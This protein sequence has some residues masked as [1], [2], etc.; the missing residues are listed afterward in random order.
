M[1][2]TGPTQNKSVFRG[3][4]GLLV[5]ACSLLSINCF[6]DS[7]DPVLPSWDVEITAPLLNR[8]YTL[9]EIVRKD[10]SILRTGVGGEITYALS[11]NLQPTFLG[12]LITLSLPDTSKSVRFGAF[13]VTAA[14]V[15]VPIGIPWLPP[16]ATVPIPDT[17]IQVGDVRDTIPSFQQVTFAQ[18]TISLTVTNNLPVPIEAIAP[19]ILV[20][21]LNEVV[22]T[23]SFSPSG[24]PPNSSATASDDLS[25]KTLDNV[26]Q[27]SGIV[28]HTPGSATPV[29]LPQGS[30]LV[31]R[32]STSNLRARQ[33]VLANIPPQR[34]TDNDSAQIHLDDST[35]VKELHI[36]SGVFTLSFENRI[37]LDMLFKYRF[38]ELE[39]P[40]AG[41]Y[42]PCEDSVFLP[43][44]GT[45]QKIV[46]LSEHRIMSR[47]PDPIRSMTVISS[48]ILPSG[49]GTPVTVNDT[50]KVLISMTGSVPLVADS[51]V[52]VLKPTWLN[53]SKSVK[54]NFG[55]LPTRFSGQLNIPSAALGLGNLSRFDFPLDL[56]LKIAARRNAAGDSAFLAVPASARRLQ[57]GEDSI[58]FDA[59][60]VG[61]FLSQ[62]AGR[63]PDSLRICGRV[64]VNPADVYNPN[65]LG[66]IGEHTPFSGQMHLDIPLMLG[67]VDGT[68]GD[69]V[70][71]GDTTGDGHRDYQID[72][73]R[74]KSVNSGRLYIEVE[75]GMPLQA[76]LGMR[77]LRGTKEGLLR[78]PQSGIPV[79][80]TPATVNGQ[81][82]VTAPT[83]S[84]SV[85]ELSEQDVRQF[86]PAEWL[87]YAIALQT[88]PGNP[89]VRFRTNDYIKVRVWTRM[90]YRVNR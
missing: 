20:N 45:G 80:I 39:R 65:V 74:L 16:G 87:S 64:L 51:V 71:V 90:S 54:M 88:T 82:Q 40:T 81:G 55:E 15:V 17:T 52:G 18:G 61:Q 6:N 13:R 59:A 57:P 68:F 43:A 2:S 3:L 30:P 8:S 76:G 9:L 14:D 32:L 70:S 21:N 66:R 49:S 58:A 48:V 85:L 56:Y 63:F 35:L 33:A 47:T 26:V 83:R 60:E 75:N 89:A 5:S 19:I 84:T 12:N 72:K 62:F 22:A 38:V 77:L 69:T 41:T 27:L 34:L 50:D 79:T 7:L 78:L 23:F 28:F 37:S 46:D 44:H 73:E 53:V 29:T 36:K 67:I 86:D 24:I 10:S 25:G 31:V 4:V 42:A 1:T 11:E